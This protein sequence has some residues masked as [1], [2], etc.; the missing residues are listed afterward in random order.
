MNLFSFSISYPDTE[1]CTLTRLVTTCYF[2][3]FYLVLCIAG[4]FFYVLINITLI[5]HC[6]WPEDITG[7]NPEPG[8]SHW[9]TRPNKTA[10]LYQ[11]VMSVAGV[12][13][14]NFCVLLDLQSCFPVQ[15]HSLNTC[16]NDWGQTSCSFTD[17]QCII[18]W[19]AINNLLTYVKIGVLGKKKAS[20]VC[21]LIKCSCCIDTWLYWIELLVVNTFKILLIVNIWPKTNDSCSK[22]NAA[23]IFFH[24]P[25][26]SP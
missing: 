1:S 3:C 17:Y 22:E 10:T 15:T 4:G 8:G 16:G 25:S 18:L 11:E 5:F 26:L 13:L 2:S 20:H 6:S 7:I 19:H 24:Q 9:K 23:F 12:L 14:P 21:L